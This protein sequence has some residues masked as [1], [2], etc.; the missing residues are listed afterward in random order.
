MSYQCKAVYAQS[1]PP[2]KEYICGVTGEQGGEVAECGKAALIVQH[3]HKHERQATTA[4][5]RFG[6]V[7]FVYSRR[8]PFHPQR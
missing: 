2:S 3:E 4:A 7:S 6:I 8:R 5:A 1:E